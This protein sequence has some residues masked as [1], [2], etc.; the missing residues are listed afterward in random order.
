M[1]YNRGFTL[2]EIAIVLVII[3]LIIGGV[4]K[5]QELIINSKIKSVI[6]GAKSISAAIYTYQDRYKAMPGDDDISQTHLNDA[7][8][9]NGNGDG[10]LTDDEKPNLFAHLR[11]SGLISGSGN[12]YPKHTFGGNIIVHTKRGNFNGLTICFEN[13]DGKYAALIDSS[14][15]DGNANEGSVQ[16]ANKKTKYTSGTNHEICWQG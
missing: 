16:D 7:T 1:K 12:S 8:Q 9:V 11:K 10:L 2:I 5:G 15:D 14:S 13:I 4:L 3:S 6:N